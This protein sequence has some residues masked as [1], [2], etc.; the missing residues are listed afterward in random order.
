MNRRLTMALLLATM[1]PFALAGASTTSQRGTD[2]I[3]I[4]LGTIAPK[5]SS[6]H[7]ILADMGKQ[8]QAQDVDL[9]IYAGGV[10]G[11]EA[12]MVQY[13]RSGA[14]DAALLTGVGLGTIDR[15][16]EA[17]QSV[18]M[19]FRSLQEV[20]YTLAR[21]QPRLE[22]SLRDKGFV[23]LFWGDAGW[24]RFFSKRPIT[25]PDD[26]RR[27]KLFAWSSDALAIELYKANGFRPVPLETN[28]I[29]PGLQT[30]MIEAIPMPPYLALTT[31][32]SAHAPNM[33]VIDWSPLVGALV[34]TEK[35]WNRLSPE[36]QRELAR[37]AALAGQQMKARNRRES[38]L[39]VESMK[40]RNLHVTALSP[41]AEAE[42]SRIAEKTYPRLRG[43]KIPADLFDEMLRL[44]GE[45]RSH[46]EAAR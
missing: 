41:S 27:M 30:G 11:G 15:S 28:D 24:V 16:A 1:T 42:W 40:K 44:V 3:R 7:R 34:V 19:L 17:I 43:Q 33:L 9:K 21:L 20:D 6:F 26:L 29:L 22:R 46:Q 2:M 18:P 35:C 14:L 31:Q 23:V 39:A 13:M 36:R 12:E 45:Y 38:D 25:R 10:R 5:D 4:K 37:A 32:V 8:W